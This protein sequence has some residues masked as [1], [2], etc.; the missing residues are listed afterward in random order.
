MGLTQDGVHTHTEA[1]P[2]GVTELLPWDKRGLK[3]LRGVLGVEW[4]IPCRGTG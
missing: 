4:L 3:G 2:P 1:I